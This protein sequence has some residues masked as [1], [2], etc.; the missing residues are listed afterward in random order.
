MEEN[1]LTYRNKR[2]LKISVVAAMILVATYFD[3]ARKTAPNGGTVA[4]LTYGTIGLVAILLLMFQGVRKRWYR[5]TLGTVQGWLSFHVYIGT[6]TLLIIPLHAGFEFHLDLHTLAFV[7]LAIVI[8][9]GIIGAFLYR[10]LPS[11][12]RQSG[13]ELIDGQEIDSE[14]TRIMKQMRS[15]CEDKSDIFVIKCEEKIGQVLPKKHLGWRLLFSPGHASAA[16]S[17]SMPGWQGDIE[18]IP[19][20]EQEDFQRVSALA[21]QMERLKS[22]F[23]PQMRVKNLLEAWLYI[24]LPLS[25]AMMVAIV[26]HLVLVFFY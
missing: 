6:L 1:F 13:A 4:G 20:A 3:Y 26:I 17:A 19:K 12:V 18:Q 15:L 23:I 25:M 24:H 9:S 16:G 5:S 21:L 14:M 2:W 7:L 10:A 22:R 11:Q 8:V